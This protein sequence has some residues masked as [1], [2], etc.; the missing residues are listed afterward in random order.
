M[1]QTL[2][3]MGRLDYIAC[4]PYSPDRNSE[5]CKGWLAAQQAEEEAS[6]NWPYDDKESEDDYY[7]DDLFDGECP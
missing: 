1:D 2:Y 4:V 6:L 3:E 5:W 7:F